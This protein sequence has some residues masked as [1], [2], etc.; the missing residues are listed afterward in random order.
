MMAATTTDNEAYQEII[1]ELDRLDRAG[2]L[3]RETYLALYRRAQE[4]IG[5]DDA[6]LFSPFLQCA[7]R[8]WLREIGLNV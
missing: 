3:T 1:Q 6:I 2:D 4:A 8:D 5:K 7:E